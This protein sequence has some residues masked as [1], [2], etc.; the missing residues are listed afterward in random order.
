MGA[1]NR[2]HVNDIF[3]I[4]NIR[5][6]EIFLMSCFGLD[7]FG[8]WN[9]LHT[10]IPRA[11]QFVRAILYPAGHVGIGRAAVGRVVLEASILRRIVRW[12]NHDAV[13]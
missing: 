8:K 7:S 3:E 9:P 5:Q 2:I 1:A 6:D 10:D 12:R 13:G 4:T 11:Q